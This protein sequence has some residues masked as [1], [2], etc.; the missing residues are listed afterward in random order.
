MKSRD[1]INI[2]RPYSK[3]EDGL[4]IIERE[5]QSNDIFDIPID[6]NK[7]EFDTIHFNTWHS[8]LW[9]II[10]PSKKDYITKDNSDFHFTQEHNGENLLNYLSVVKNI[11][12]YKFASL[13]RE[14][15]PKIDAK[16]SKRIMHYWRDLGYI[17]FQ[18]YG[19]SVKVSPTNLLFIETEAGLRAFLTGFRNQKF[20]KKLVAVCKELKLII[21]LT[22]HSKEHQEILPH[23][24]EIYDK[25]GDLNKFKVLAKKAGIEYI[26]N[27]ENPLNTSYSIYQLACFYTQRSVGEFEVYLSDK[28]EYKTDHHR[29]LLFDP[30]NCSW[31]ETNKNVSSMAP[32]VLIRYDGFKDRQILHV[33]KDEYG[34][35]VLDNFALSSFKIINSNI[36]LKKQHFVK[37]TSDFYV[38]L[39]ISL[40]FWIERGLT[41]MNAEI[42]VIEWVDKKAYRKYR[43]IHDDIIKTIEEKLNQTAIITK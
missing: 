15:N 13:I 9:K 24:I 26:N 23:R 16:F 19:E 1:I 29:K 21:K 35:K 20:I 2:S 14:L 38:P 30:D 17:N 40:P 8:K 34:S 42:P 39:N 41:L 10:K 36:F 37:S 11:D 27:I 31:K 28:L 6:F 25:L 7:K 22:N 3:D 33:F 18:L 5:I 32:P 4:N 12:T 43:N